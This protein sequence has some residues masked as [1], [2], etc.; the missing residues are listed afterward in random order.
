[1][2]HYGD[3]WARENTTAFDHA[4]S[5]LTV[6]QVANEPAIYVCLDAS[7]DHQR[8]FIKE[9][10]LW[11][12]RSDGLPSLRKV[13]KIATHRTDSRRIYALME[14]YLA[15]GEGHVFLSTDR[16]INWADI[17][18]NLPN[19]PITDLIVHPDDL[20]RLYVSSEFGF[21]R[22]LDGGA[23]WHRYN[24]GIPPAVMVTEMKALDLTWWDDG[25]YY[26]VAGTYGRSIWK[27]NILLSDPSGLS[28]DGP[29]PAEAFRLRA[30]PNPLT[31]KSTINFE[32]PCAGPVHLRVFD[33]QGRLV[34]TLL[35]KTLPAGS[36]RLK[37]NG[38]DA[39]GREMPSGTYLI[40]LEVKGVRSGAKLTLLR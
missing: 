35:D 10:G 5:E 16:G 1:M 28:Q 27:R 31:S 26:I 38:R 8:V 36:H 2:D 22:S 33:T 6:S 21:F 20:N 15:E 37:W 17:S 34:T 39:R 29:G 3:T 7:A 25:G 30:V 24:E 14:G 18:G 19:V 9:S 11:H 40:Q 32:I 4:V 12:E 13:R 23:T